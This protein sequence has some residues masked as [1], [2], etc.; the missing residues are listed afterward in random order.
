MSRSY[1]LGRGASAHCGTAR[2]EEVAQHLRWSYR[3]RPFSG[4]AGYSL[5][6]HTL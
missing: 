1:E 3:A 2:S 6:N 4:T 5:Q